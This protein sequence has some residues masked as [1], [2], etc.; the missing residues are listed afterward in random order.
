M[1]ASKTKIMDLDKTHE[2][3]N[4]LVDNIHVERVQSF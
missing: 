4:I 3:K 1:D 2:N